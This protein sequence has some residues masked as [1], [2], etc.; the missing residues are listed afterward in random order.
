MSTANISGRWRRRAATCRSRTAL[1]SISLGASDLYRLLWLR[2]KIGHRLNAGAKLTGPVA[3][4]GAS[5][6]SDS[7]SAQ[8]VRQSWPA[9]K[10]VNCRAC[11]A[12]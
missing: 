5:L 1:A 8:P 3:N 12:Q 7:L 10:S 11:R 4:G 6:S 9:R 2:P